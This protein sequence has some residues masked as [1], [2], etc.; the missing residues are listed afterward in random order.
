MVVVA[1]AV[2]VVVCRRSRRCVGVVISNVFLLHAVASLKCG[3]LLH[4]FAVVS[5]FFF[6]CVCVCAFF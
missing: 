1:V 4:P 2:A 6:V 3:C 5:F